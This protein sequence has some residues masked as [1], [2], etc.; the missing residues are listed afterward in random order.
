MKLT[1]RIHELAQQSPNDDPRK[2]AKE[3][4][5]EL[6]DEDL[7]ELI[8][9]EILFAQRTAVRTIETAAFIGAKIGKPATLTPATPAFRALMDR[10]FK[11]GDGSRVRFADATRRDFQR[12]IA[13]ID[14]QLAGLQRTR[15]FYVECV[16]LMDEAHVVRFGELDEQAA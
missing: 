6:T 9:H 11:L 14:R 12:R 2:L 13:L 4:L 1:T 16:R 8:A 7:V 3:L 5:A 10:T 15:A